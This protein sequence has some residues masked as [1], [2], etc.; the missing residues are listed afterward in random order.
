MNRYIWT[1]K[2]GPLPKRK[3]KKHADP[4]ERVPEWHQFRAMLLSGKMKPQEQIA[5]KFLPELKKTTGV[6]QP[7]RIGRLRLKEMLK[8]AG[9]DSDYSLNM[10]IPEPDQPDYRVLV[11]TY[12]PPLVKHK[13]EA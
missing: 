2:D 8:D 9:L 13:K 4:M 7:W 10:Y 5:F 11:V 6:T 12:E 3:G 1:P